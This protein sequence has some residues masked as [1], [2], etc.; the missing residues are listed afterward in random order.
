MLGGDVLKDFNFEFVIFEEKDNVGY[1]TLNNPTQMNPVTVEVMRD[2]I[3][4]LNYCEE[5]DSIR[6]IVIRGAG[7]NFSAG[8]NVKAMKERLDKGINTTKRGIRAGGEF[9]MRLKT[10]AKPTIAWIEGAVAG[11]GCSI[12]MAC[13]FSIADENSK[14]V[15]AFVNIGYI[16][17]GGIVY[18]LQKAVGAVK[19]TELLMSGN[20]FMG[21]D[22]AELGI[23]TKAVLADELEEVVNKYIKKY[24]NGPTVAYGQLKNLINRNNYAELNSCMQNEVSSQYICSTTEDHREAVNAFVEKRKANFRGK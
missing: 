19:T 3:E 11:V 22:A 16:P 1:I 21:K 23:I 7:G 2:L 17:D 9:I 10:I 5:N 20:K 13:D 8:G 15:F 12:A 24:S 4:C 14:F 18:M 6:A